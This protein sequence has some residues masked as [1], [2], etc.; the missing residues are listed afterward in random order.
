MSFGRNHKRRK[1]QPVPADP[2]KSRAELE[3]LYGEEVWSPDTFGGVFVVTAIIGST[4]VVRRKS[5]NLVG[6]VEV[7]EGPPQ[8]YYKFT[9]QPSDQ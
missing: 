6:T 5:D 9:P 3:A 7:Q 8:F 2:P 4:L 1:Q